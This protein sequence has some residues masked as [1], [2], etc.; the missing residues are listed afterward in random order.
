MMSNS[1][2]RAFKRSLNLNESYK[3]YGQL[4]GNL[5]RTDSPPAV[6][7]ACMTATQQT[8]ENPAVAVAKAL[9][10][11]DEYNKQQTHTKT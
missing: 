10:W 4:V 11:L 1:Y 2:V 7:M 6:H 8:L 5:S 9:Q 3:P